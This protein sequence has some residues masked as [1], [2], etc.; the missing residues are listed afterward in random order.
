MQA[1]K[2][3]TKSK[4]VIEQIIAKYDAHQ[5]CVQV[6]KREDTKKVGLP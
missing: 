5:N 4:A 6:F 3:V 2:H 1:L